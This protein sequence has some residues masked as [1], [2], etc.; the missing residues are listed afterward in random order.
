MRESTTSIVVFGCGF[1]TQ[2]NGDMCQIL[3]WRDNRVGQ[4]GAT[5]CE[6]KRHRFILKCDNERK[7]K[8][9]EECGDSSMYP[10]GSDSKRPTCKRSIVKRSCE[11]GFK[12][13]EAKCKTLKISIKRNTNLRIASD[14]PLLSW[15]RQ[16]RQFG[17]DVIEIS[18]TL[19]KLILYL[20]GQ[21]W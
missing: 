8:S 11:N 3:I 20:F 9:L 14:S 17:R 12:R 18:K 19:I 16:A 21:A 15:L 1:M 13:R 10:C 7:T 6:R 5:C 2:Q 4:I